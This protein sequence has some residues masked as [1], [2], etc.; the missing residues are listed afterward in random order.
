MVMEA[1][2]KYFPELSAEQQQQFAQLETLY[3]EWNAQINV[4]SRK[5]MESFY[6][7]HV[8]H[9]LAIAKVMG[10]KAGAKVLD[11]GTGGGFP[12]IPLAIL[13]PET[14]FLLVDSIGKKIKVVQAVAEAL[15]L[16]NVE[17]RH[18]RAEEVKG[19]FDFVVSRAV[20]R[21][22]PFYEWI[23]DKFGTEQRHSLANGVLY[24]KGGDLKEELDECGQPY[25]IHPI[26]AFFEDAFF[27]TKA[28]V[29]VQAPRQFSMPKRR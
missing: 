14:Q 16:A 19:K 18:Q 6:T 26:S 7:H 27:E 11:V 29:Y 13:F 15:G 10:F 28:V 17:A 22:A 24:L 2:I 12:G 20:T 5:D 25:T 23:K 3:T 4:I 1:I 8:L 21:M 9:S